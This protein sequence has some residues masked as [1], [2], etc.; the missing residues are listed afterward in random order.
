MKLIGKISLIVLVVILITGCTGCSKLIG[1]F[2]DETLR[3]NTE[4]MLDAI[5]ADD[6]EQAYALIDDYYSS[7]DAAP[8]LEEIRTVLA[9]VEDYELS[10]LAANINTNLSDGVSTTSATAE[11]SIKTNS[12]TFII[13][14]RKFSTS[15][16]LE[17][18]RV[19]PIESTNYYSVGSFKNMKGAAAVQWILL[20][21]NLVIAALTVSAVVDCCRNKIRLKALWIIIIIIGFFSVGASYSPTSFSLNLNLNWIFAYTSLIAYGGGLNVIRFLL[22]IGPVVYFAAR[23]ALLRSANRPET[24]EDPDD[25]KPKLQYDIDTDA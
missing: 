21:S 19:I 15:D 17:G 10:L 5:I 23:K 14:V 11:Y 25:A 7:Q 4:K 22:P 12:D 1:M 2:E 6:M 9:G 18:F 8:G 13:Y 3:M 20:F 16:D 24:A